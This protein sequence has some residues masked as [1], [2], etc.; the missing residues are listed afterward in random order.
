MALINIIT[1]KILGLPLIAW[2]GMLS[3][4]LLITTATLGYFVTKGR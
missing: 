1:F 4:I 2:G 3:L